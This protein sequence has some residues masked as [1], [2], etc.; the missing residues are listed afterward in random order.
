MAGR[1]SHLFHFQHHGVRVAVKPDGP[2]FLH[3]AGAFSLVPEFCAAAAEIVGFSGGERGVP[4][5]F[6]HPAQHEYFAAGGILGN[7]G[8]QAPPRALRGG[9]MGE[10]RSEIERD[11]TG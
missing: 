9:G 3:V 7:G 8:Y 6:I 2:D 11:G 1:A 10:I 4:C 5:L